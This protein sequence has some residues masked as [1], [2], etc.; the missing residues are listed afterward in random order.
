[1]VGLFNMPCGR[2][3]HRNLSNGWELLNT[4]TEKANLSRSFFAR[5]VVKEQF[6]KSMTLRGQS[7]G[8]HAG[9]GTPGWRA[10]LGSKIS[11]IFLRSCISL[12]FPVFLGTTKTGVFHGLLDGS[13]CPASNCCCTSSWG[14]SSLSFFSGHWLT[15]T[16]VSDSQV[17]DKGQ[18]W[19]VAAEEKVAGWFVLPTEWG[20]PYPR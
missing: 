18:A 16:G 9:F 14:F 8:I 4:G 11:L 15:H 1:M 17:R 20:G 19:T 7:F 5:G 10:P 12:H 3:F 13:G 2:T 6:F